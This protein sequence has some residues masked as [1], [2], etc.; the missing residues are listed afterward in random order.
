MQRIR[1]VSIIAHI[2]HGKSTLAD[3][4]LLACGAISPRE[5]RE[6]FLDDMDLER[7][8]GITIKANRATLSY[9]CDGTCY[10]INLIDTPGHVDFHYEV[11]RALAA[12][13]GAILLVDATQGVQAQTVANAYLA[14]EAD[15]AIIPVVNKI[16]L[17]AARPEDVA[18]EM[19]QVLGLPADEVLFVSAKTGEGV[20]DLLRAIVEKV[21]APNGSPDGPLKALVHDAKFDPHR[22]VVC[23]VRIF[24]GSVRKGDKVLLMA[25]GRTYTVSEV[26]LFTPKM[27][28]VEALSAGQVGYVIA[29]IKTLRDVTIGETITLAERPAT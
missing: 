13:E 14:M 27:R 22:G 6:Q 1:N 5:F 2:D 11:S 28:P 18:L 23:M 26:G 4:F 3:R 10:T 16:D 29:G 19:E 24:D 12:C 20:D 21:P 17:P 8:M 9:Y 25:A 15:L 7:E